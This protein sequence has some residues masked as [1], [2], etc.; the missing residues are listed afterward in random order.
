MSPKNY[1]TVNTCSAC[2]PLGAALALKGIAQAMPLIHGSQGCS[3][4]MRLYLVRHFREPID[5]ASSALNEKDAIYGGEANLQAAVKNVINRYNPAIIG[6]ITGCLAETIGD[7]IDR[8]S[9]EC[10]KSYPDITLVPIRAPGFADDWSAGFHTA[11]KQVVCHLARRTKGSRAINFL[12]GIISP[13][14]TRWL[15]L[16]LVDSG[17]SAII[18]PDNSLTLDA[19]LTV[20]CLEKPLS[21]IPPGGTKCSDIVKMGDSRGTI[22]LSLAAGEQSAG[23]CLKEDFSIERRHLGLPIGLRATDNFFGAIKELGGRITERYIEPRGRL[24]DAMADAHRRL[25]GLKAVIYGEPDLTAAMANF[26]LELGMEPVLLASASTKLSQA[27]EIL[28]ATYNWPYQPEIL[29]AADF[30]KIA[31]KIAGRH[32]DLLIGDSNGRHLANA[33]DIPLLRVGF[34]VYDR[35]G[36]GRIRTLGYEAAIRLV[37]QIAN[38]FQESREDKDRLKI[39]DVI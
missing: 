6:L 16:L 31:Q 11:V 12:P 32:L 2:Q 8:I 19:P 20:D 9:A 23:V 14:D 3:T 7:D 1:V 29:E 33:L 39:E 4:Y 10:A 13:A 28:A 26:I 27:I 37:D 36:A 24:L 21:A 25:F 17:I 22:E 38:I 15:K 34:P 5:I 35:Y 18:L 30:K